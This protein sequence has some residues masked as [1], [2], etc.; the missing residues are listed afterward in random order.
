MVQVDV[1]VSNEDAYPPGA[2]TDLA[3]TVISQ[4]VVN[5]GVNITIQLKWTAPGDE[6]DTGTGVLIENQLSVIY[7]FKF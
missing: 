7:K 2:V 6:L 5:G 1:A 4:P 3:V